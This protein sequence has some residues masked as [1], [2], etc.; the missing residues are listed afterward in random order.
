MAESSKT[1]LADAFL[2]AQKVME[3]PKRT[4]TN[5]HFK[6]SFAP[7]DECIRVAKTALN[8]EGIAFM[9]PCVSTDDG[10]IGVQT[11]ISGHGEKADLGTLLG[12]PPADP[13]KVGSW[14][15][16]FRRYALCAALGLAA[17]DDDD[18]NA[19]SE[20]A[21]KPKASKPEPMEWAERIVAVAKDNQTGA[22]LREH[23]KL[24]EKATTAAYKTALKKVKEADRGEVELLVSGAEPVEDELSGPEIPF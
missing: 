24:D 22:K 2:A 23:L 7:L 1:T 10:R 17:E 20:T 14:L 12:T 5:P 15:T 9:Q 8:G 18:A 16:Y 13:Q 21:S 11:V 19:A 4:A 6:S 3:P